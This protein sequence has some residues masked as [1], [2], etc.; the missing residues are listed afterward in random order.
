MP[1][2][3]LATRHSSL[4]KRGGERA[5]FL[6][7]RM[8]ESAKITLCPIRGS[9]CDRESARRSEGM[10][11]VVQATCPGCRKVL[12]IPADWLH[13]AFRCKY[14]RTVIQAR[15]NDTGG[16][17]TPPS[18][19]LAR[20]AQPVQKPPSERRARPD[21]PVAPPA[22]PVAIQAP[23]ALPVASPVPLVP[24]SSAP[25]S[26]AV[27]IA[28]PVAEPG[29]VFAG[30]DEP[31]AEINPLRRRRR[32]GGPGWIGFVIGLL[33]LALTGAAVFVFW[34]DLKPV[35]EGKRA[36]KKIDKEKEQVSNDDKRPDKDPDPI[37]RPDGTKPKDPVNT[38]P[39]K[40]PPRD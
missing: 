28:G 25:T 38:R 40:D 29:S 6:V 13:Q 12:R 31:E 16:R 7:R 9:S 33:L 39:P 2:S 3:P 23:P 36:A 32:S 26:R 20:A 35:F 15:P 1:H 30:F 4:P 37:K 8:E 10:S 18:G 14:C 5:T 11:A 27:P 34:D 19:A 24:G 22:I 17:P 21:L